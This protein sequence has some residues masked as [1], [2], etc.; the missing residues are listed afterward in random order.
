[1]IRK[2]IFMLFALIF[3][4]TVQACDIQPVAPTGLPLPVTQIPFYA[5]DTPAPIVETVTPTP[6]ITAP[7]TD[8]PFVIAP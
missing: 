2:G 3:L 5:S 4:I 7:I 8:T 1:M 6:V